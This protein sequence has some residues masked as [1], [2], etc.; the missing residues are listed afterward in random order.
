M[1]LSRYFLMVMLG[2]LF[3]SCKK[4][5]SNAVPETL[6]YAKRG[7]N[8]GIYD[9]QGRFVILRG[10]NYNSL[11]DYWQGNAAVANV[12]PYEENDLKLMASYGVNCIR[13]LFSWSKLEPVRGQYD[14]DYINQLKTVIET[15]AKYDIYVLLD[16]HQDAWG[17][18]IVSP[19]SEACDK[20]NKGWDGAPDWAT[21][22]DG[23]STCTSDGSRESAPAVYHAFQHFW[24]NTDGIQDAAVN[25]WKALAKQT[26]G[27][28]NV[29]GYDLLNEPNLGY[30]PINLEAD[31]LA[32]FYRKATNAI[33]A[34][35]QESKAFQHIIFFEMS[36]TWNGQPI[37]FVPSVDLITDE[38]TI[39]APHHYFESISYLLTIEQGL[40]LLYGLSGAYKTGT[41]IGEFGFFGN[42]V[43]DVEKYKRFAK[44]EDANFSSST[45][46]QWAQAPGD[47]HG[48]SWDGMQ[49]DNTSTHLL[50]VD[51]NGN[52]TGVKNE[53]Y[54]NVLNRSRPNAIF[55]KPVKLVSNPDNGTME[56]QAK[57][58][59][60]GV[61]TIWI[62][63]RFG[64][65]HIAGTNILST[66][67][68]KV[69]G[70]YIAN[71][72]VSGN[73]MLNVSF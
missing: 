38:N 64:E 50:E 4:E 62:P 53:Y 43:D 32:K 48:I 39:F 72:T 26:A 42:P 24:D 55:G 34:A 11:G 67:V 44:K 31:K 9:Q 23:A 68:T 52:F 70:G 65:P 22:T 51:K 56:L 7:D 36:V 35:E 60:Q 59:S 30:R 57:S 41:F 63:D 17:K 14:Q 1:K 29:V 16:M 58:T 40:D 25:A 46:W 21:M 28:A 2:I 69:E 20:P 15:A 18:Y 54:L 12:K 61:T 47:P 19:A 13:L 8:P 33:R 6:L 66:V 73:Y 45:W 49:Y 5:K 10:V 37:P 3:F 27:Y 71:V